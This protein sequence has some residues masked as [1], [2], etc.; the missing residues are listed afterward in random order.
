M[1]VWGFCVC[2]C[3]VL[4]CLFS[5]SACFR[6]ELSS[7]RL[8]YPWQPV[9]DTLNH[10]T[11]PPLVLMCIGIP[12]LLA[13]YITVLLFTLWESNEWKCV[14]WWSPIF[15]KCAVGFA[16]GLA[17]T[18]ARIH[19]LHSDAWFVNTFCDFRWVSTW[20]MLETTCHTAVPAFFTVSPTCLVTYTRSCTVKIPVNS[21]AIRYWTKLC[22]V[23]VPHKK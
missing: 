14:R 5:R 7:K 6:G 15:C 13:E 21:C 4:N 18:G 17:F 16:Y 23:L 19:E 12:P 3:P 9:C 2:V 11:A 20:K 10:T 8:P 1:L 22:S